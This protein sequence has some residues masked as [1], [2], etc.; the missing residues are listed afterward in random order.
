M[1][2]AGSWGPPGLLRLRA[3]LDRLV[4]RF[5]GIETRRTTAFPFLASS[6]SPAVEVLDTDQEF[7]VRAEVPGLGPE[8]LQL[9]VSGNALVVAGEKKSEK[10]REDKGIVRSELRYGSFRRLIPIP[11]GAD[12]EKVSAEYD[13]GILTVHLPKSESERA[14]RI[15][16]SSPKSAE[17]PAPRG[18]GDESRN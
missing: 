15:A 12:A 2:G 16:V 1:S 5:F 7:V 9:T 14:R 8:D 11:V 6:W 3:E 10:R 13:R 18:P 17:P 4:D